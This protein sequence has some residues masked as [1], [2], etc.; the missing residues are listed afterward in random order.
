ML[1]RKAKQKMFEVKG[2]LSIFLAYVAV[3]DHVTKGLKLFK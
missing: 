3:A 1:F 2:I